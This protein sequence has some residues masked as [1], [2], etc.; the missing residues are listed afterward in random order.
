MYRFCKT[1]KSATSFFKSV[2]A[3]TETLFKKNS[4]SETFCLFFLCTFGLKNRTDKMQKRYQKNKFL[5]FCQ[6]HTT[7]FYYL[8][9]I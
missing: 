3:L 8:L 9:Y 1:A 2:P 5:V 6:R 4:E 7:L